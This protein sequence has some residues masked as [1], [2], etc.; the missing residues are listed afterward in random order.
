MA[1]FDVYANP[2]ARERRTTPFFLDVQNDFL[3]SLATR[4]MI[5]LRRE[6]EFGAPANRLNPLIQVD[7]EALVLDTAGIGA[8]PLN[9]LKRPLVNLRAQRDEITTALDTLFGAY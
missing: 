1:R 9:L 3:G 7:D 5:P 4:V 6:A 2:V 8:V